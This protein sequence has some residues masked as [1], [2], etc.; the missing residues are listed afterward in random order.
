MNT[1]KQARHMAVWLD[2]KEARIFAFHSDESNEVT[3][4]APPHND[5]HKHTKGQLRLKEHPED[6]KR[7][8]H[9]LTTALHGAEQLLVVG[10]GSAKLEFIRYVHAHER[11]LEEKVVGVETVDHPSDAQLVAYA[12]TYFR[13]TDRMG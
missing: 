6:T 13:R 10:P 11:T 1:D 7:F 12:K 5:H 3:L 4:H 8:F 9:G 2:H